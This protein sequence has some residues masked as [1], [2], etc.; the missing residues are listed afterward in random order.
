MCVTHG[1]SVLIYVP[2]VPSLCHALVMRDLELCQRPS[3][4]LL[5]WSHHFVL[6][7][8]LHIVLHL[9][10]CTCWPLYIWMKPPWSWYVIFL[11]YSWVWLASVLLRVFVSAHRGDWSVVVFCVGFLPRFGIGIFWLCGV[12]SVVFS[13]FYLGDQAFQECC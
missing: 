7:I 8:D 10:I 1:L 4:H 5:R 11:M 13:P 9:L 2:S 12:T 3:L 6:I